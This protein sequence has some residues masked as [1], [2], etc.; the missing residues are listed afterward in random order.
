MKIVNFE[1]TLAILPI[2]KTIAVMKACFADF[3]QGKISQTPRVVQVLPDGDQQNL[4]AMMPAY[5]GPDRVFG[6]K[7]IT[8]F[9]KNAG[10]EYQSHMGQVMLFDSQHGQ[11][12]ALIDANAITYIRTAAVTG[13]GTDFLAKKEAQDLALI[14]AGQQSH[15]HLAAMLAV[16]PIKTVHVF[17][18]N[19]E[20]VARSIQ[21]MQV[22]YPA[23][24][25]IAANSV[26]EAVADA[27]I[28]CT[29]TPSKQAFLEKDWVKPGVHINAIG[30]FT[31][32]TREITSDLMVASRLFVDD[33]QAANNESGDYLI[34]LT[35][36]V[37]TK[38]HLQGSLGELVTKQV[39]G[40]QN[41]TEIT[42]FDAVGL[43]VED[44]CCAEYVYQLVKEG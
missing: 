5:L 2:E 25:F 24:T 14:G 20:Q 29:L 30:T 27:D 23:V 16:R 44:L 8:A 43:A 34:P 22:A 38:N 28:I 39:Q 32:T 42:I 41:E 31:P 21:R 15:S 36:Q 4:F 37:I 6:S 9:P 1:E 11:P 17:D 7:V 13:L 26:Q 40:R 10:T 18:L 33:Y 35:E 3:E 19:A 12:V